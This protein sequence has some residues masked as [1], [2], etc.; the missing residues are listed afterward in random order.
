MISSRVRDGLVKLESLLSSFLSVI[1]AAANLVSNGQ[2]YIIEV[3]SFIN[4]DLIPVADT[5]ITFER[6]TSFWIIITIEFLE[7]RPSHT[8]LEQCVAPAWHA[9]CIG[10]QHAWSMN[11]PI[12]FNGGHAPRIPCCFSRTIRVWPALNVLFGLNS[13]QSQSQQRTYHATMR[14]I[15]PLELTMIPVLHCP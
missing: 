12:S 2:H 5:Y 7:V 14:D 9:T 6:R 1:V 15:S 11:V 4:I 10:T 13:I 3:S 8:D